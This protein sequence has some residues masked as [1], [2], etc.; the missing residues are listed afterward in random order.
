MANWDLLLCVAVGELLLFNDQN[1]IVG[2][3]VNALYSLLPIIK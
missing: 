2:K 1:L 3:C